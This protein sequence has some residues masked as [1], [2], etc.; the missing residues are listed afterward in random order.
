[1][2]RAGSAS[3]MNGGFPPEAKP[4][5]N[6]LLARMRATARTGLEGAG[7]GAGWGGSSGVPHGGGD[8]IR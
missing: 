6:R 5:T 3:Q 4:V 2:P 8:R 7:M 1:M